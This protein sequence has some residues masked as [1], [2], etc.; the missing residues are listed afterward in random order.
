MVQQ[1]PSTRDRILAATRAHLEAGGAAG[2]R[3]DAV[4]DSAG[5][6]KRML[7]HYFADKAGL[8]AAGYA[9]VDVDSSDDAA[10]ERAAR[11]LAWQ[12]LEGR[13]ADAESAP[14]GVRSA[15]TP[16][17]GREQ[18]AMALCLGL[19]LVVFGVHVSRVQGL[20]AMPWRER[21]D[22]WLARARGG[23]KPRVRV[24]PELRRLS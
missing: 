5:V 4:A 16:A 19:G 23:P 24:L 17:A 21:L 12:A 9:S 20:E 11:L 15:G 1:D 14:S 10:F 8:V 18:A 3:I 7:Y 2:L 13:L 6:N 22:A